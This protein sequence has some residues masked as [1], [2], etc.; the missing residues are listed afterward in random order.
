MP[1]LSTGVADWLT[2][3]PGIFVLVAV[4]ALVLSALGPLVARLVTRA[5]TAVRRGTGRSAGDTPSRVRLVTRDDRADAS[6]ADRCGPPEDC[7]PVR[8]TRPR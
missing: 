4:V 1:P 5:D 3:S 2:S 6:D 8:D 7:G